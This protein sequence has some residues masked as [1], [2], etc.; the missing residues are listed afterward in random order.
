MKI[1]KTTMYYFISGKNIFPEDNLQNSK[2]THKNKQRKEN[3]RSAHC[4]N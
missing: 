1:Q 2:R 4:E 3:S